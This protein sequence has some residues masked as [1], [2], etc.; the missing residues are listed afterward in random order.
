MNSRQGWKPVRGEP[1]V[2]RW[3]DAQRDSPATRSG[4]TP[5]PTE[6]YQHQHQHQQH[7][8]T[9]RHTVSRHASPAQSQPCSLFREIRVI[10]VKLIN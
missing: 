2:L 9:Q 4:E 6:T 5:R 1:Q 10:R 8:N 7:N 3:L